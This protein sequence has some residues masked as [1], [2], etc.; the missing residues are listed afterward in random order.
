MQMESASDTDRKHCAERRAEEWERQQQQA[1]LRQLSSI[2]RLRQRL[3]GASSH[4]SHTH[5]RS[6]SGSES[7][8]VDFVP[9][10]LLD[11]SAGQV[12]M[13][14]K[15][16]GK[17]RK[18]LWCAKMPSWLVPRVGECDGGH[19]WTSRSRRGRRGSF[20]ALMRGGHFLARYHRRN[21]QLPPMWQ[22]LCRLGAV[23]QGALVRAFPRPG[24]A[25]A[26]GTGRALRPL[27]I[28]A[29]FTYDL[30]EVHL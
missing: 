16:A 1:S 28:S 24:L 10:P 23:V 22:V 9:M 18:L 7:K 29:R 20:A 26:L 30:G 3:F 27:M 2:E 14:L 25:A 19:C 15:D 8:R 12:D 13:H 17:W 21:H 6:A 4:A 5:V 11:R